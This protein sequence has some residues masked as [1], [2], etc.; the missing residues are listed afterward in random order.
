MASAA[1][2][3]KTVRFCT[4]DGT[5]RRAVDESAT[6]NG[7]G[8]TT[9]TSSN[10]VDT[11]PIGNFPQIKFLAT[12]NKKYAIVRG[13]LVKKLDGR[14][15]TSRKRAASAKQAAT[16]QLTRG[17]TPVDPYDVILDGDGQL[18]NHERR[19]AH[20]FLRRYMQSLVGH[21]PSTT[22]VAN[23]L[24]TE[25]RRPVAVPATDLTPTSC[26]AERTASTRFF[27]RHVQM[28][29]I[30]APSPPAKQID[31]NPLAVCSVIGNQPAS[32]GHQTVSNLAR[33]NHSSPL[34]ERLSGS[35]TTLDGAN[36]QNDGNTKHTIKQQIAEDV[37]TTNNH[38]DNWLHLSADGDRKIRNMK[39][40]FDVRILCNTS[41]LYIISLI[42]FQHRS[43]VASTT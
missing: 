11:S 13:K 27:P 7:N 41:L 39:T 19:K 2:T 28:A 23:N 29:G 31:T 34:T 6:S 4:S 22:M 8:L 24:S 25:R 15:S 37:M 12:D 10:V 35:T 5:P 14:R 36:E 17:R 42:Y 38:E 1:V 21:R 32:G 30:L 18:H 20:T 43:L 40:V 16:R 3:A 33:I 26:R 9:S